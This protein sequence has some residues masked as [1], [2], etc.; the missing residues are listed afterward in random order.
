MPAQACPQEVPCGVALPAAYPSSVQEPALPTSS[1]TLRRSSAATCPPGPSRQHT[2]GLSFPC[3]KIY[4]Y[5]I[6]LKASSSGTAESFPRVPGGFQQRNPLPPGLH[7]A[8]QPLL[9]GPA[10]PPPQLLS[11]PALLVHPHLSHAG[12]DSVLRWLPVPVSLLSC[13]IQHRDSSSKPS[14]AG[15]SSPDLSANPT[16]AWLSSHDLGNTCTGV[17]HRHLRCVSD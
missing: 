14:E 17:P 11:P 13:P 8:Q 9:P 1:K 10:Q 12:D 4:I 15:M 5:N 3:L 6:S 2:N 7:G 16:L